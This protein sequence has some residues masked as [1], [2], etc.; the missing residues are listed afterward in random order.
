MHYHQE[1]AMDQADRFYLMLGLFRNKTASTKDAGKAQLAHVMKKNKFGGEG[2]IMSNTCALASY[3]YASS[4]MDA[5]PGKAEEAQ[6][7]F[8]EGSE[9]QQACPPWWEAYE[10][11]YNPR[12]ELD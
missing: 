9:M 6:K 11:F 3:F 12:Y 7:F 10:S 2:Q 4:M 1:Y 5:D 8:E